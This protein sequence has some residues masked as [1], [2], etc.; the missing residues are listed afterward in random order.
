MPIFSYIFYSLQ[1][2][3]LTWMKDS[4]GLFDYESLQLNKNTIAIE[5]N[6][7]LGRSESA[8]SVCHEE[9]EGK[10]QEENLG[11]QQVRLASFKVENGNNFKTTK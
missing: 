7:V 9:D 3:A 4:Y 6:T 8:V 5:E 2:K 10:E 11:E 1:I